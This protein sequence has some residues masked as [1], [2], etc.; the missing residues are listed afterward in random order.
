[1][2]EILQEALKKQFESFQNEAYNN[3]LEVFKAQEKDLKL[4]F[5]A[6][7]DIYT[8]ASEERNNKI[9]ELKTQLAELQRKN[10]RSSTYANLVFQK[11][12]EIN[13]KRSCFEA[14]KAFLNSQ[15]KK[16]RMNTYVYKFHARGVLRKVYQGW[17]NEVDQNHRETLSVRYQQLKERVIEDSLE[18]ANREISILRRMVNEL[19]EDLRQ[20]TLAKN[21]LRYQQ[22]QAL[23][24]SISTLSLENM[25]I[26]Q[27]NLES[28]GLSQTSKLLLYK[29]SKF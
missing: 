14:W 2:G 29:H 15:K 6:E 27:R 18:A 24:R 16:T 7:K 11:K 23:L 9:Q 22:E 21:H 28:K 12:S 10:L 25:Q 1:M 19:T 17:K 3:L 4:T 5:E 13:H 26:T 20:E 8:K